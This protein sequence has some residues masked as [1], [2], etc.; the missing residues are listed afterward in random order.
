MKKQ[1]RVSVQNVSNEHVHFERCIDLDPNLVV[2]Y[3]S[4]VSSLLWL[5]SGL[6]VKVVIET[7]NY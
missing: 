7:A 5:Y 2:P 6:N 1:L 3:D 4:L